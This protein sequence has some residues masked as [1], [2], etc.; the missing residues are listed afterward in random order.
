MLQA[1]QRGGML[2]RFAILGPV[3]FV[4]ADLPET[5]TAGTGLDE[6]CLTEH[7]VL[8][9][10]GTITVHHDDGRTESFEEGT[11]FYVPPG[12]PTHH[13]T[14]AGKV[15]AAGF[16]A[17]APDVDTGPDALRELGFDPIVRPPLPELPPAT[18]RVHGTPGTVLRRGAVEAE[19]SVMGPWLFMR[20]SLGPRS[21]YTSGWCEV[22]HW[23]LL[24]DGDMSITF[25]DHVEL[26]SRGDAFYAPA[27]HR[28]ESPD[29]ATVADYTP[30]SELDG[31]RRL[32]AYRRP[33][34]SRL[35]P[36]APGEGTAGMPGTAGTAGSIRDD[37]S[38][39]GRNAR[40]DEPARNA[41]GSPEPTR[42]SNLR[43][44]RYRVAPTG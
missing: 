39:T 1:V 25:D 23:G 6:P 19:G 30:I 3:A 27:G 4:I 16:S 28:Y 8:I 14:S 7:H 2:T 37:G 40:L 41:T 32:P 15:V 5:G 10:R 42:R 12:P 26:V 20:T 36:V 22:P 11:A 31:T 35:V 33:V 17:I 44:L 38:V 29:G 9:L 13:F 43:V 21:G 34:V 24:L 18:M